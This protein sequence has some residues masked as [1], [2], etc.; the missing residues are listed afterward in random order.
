MSDRD[1]A[2]VNLAWADVLMGALAA[3]GVEHVVMSPGSRSTP[4]VLAAERRPELHLWVRVDERSAAF[5]ALGL[6]KGGGRPVVLVAT[7]GSAPA[8]WHPAVIEADQGG[9]PLVLLSANR[10]ADLHDCGANQTIDQSRLFGS[11]ARAF[12]AL[13]PPDGRPEWL[14]NLMARTLELALHPRPG[15]V[16]LDVPFAEPLVPAFPPP[17]PPVVSIPLVR[18]TPPGIPDLAAIAGRLSGRPGIIVC[19]SEDLGPEFAPLVA[20][21]ATALGVPI[22]ADPLSNLRFGEHDRSHVLARGDLFLRSPEFAVDPPDWVL[23]FGGRPV[24][25]TVQRHAAGAGVATVLMDADGRWPD[26]DRR[27]THVVRLRAEAACKALLATTPRAAPAGWL[28]RYRASERRAAQAIDTAD[29]FWEA[30]IIERLLARL[31]EDAILFAGNSMPV[32]EIDAF[33]G[34]GQRR[35]RFSGNRGASGIDGG[36]STLIGLAA[37]GEKVAGLLG[38][39]SFFHDLNGLQG[40]RDI[41]ATVIVIDNGGGGIFGYLP[42]AGLAGFREH[43]LTPLDLD[44]RHAAGLFGIGFHSAGSLDEFDRALRASLDSG[45]LDLVVAMVDREASA[46]RHQALWSRAAEGWE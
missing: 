18:E 32:R 20:A 45:H 29:G 14:A 28:E 3:L 16:H 41:D 34:T 37:A 21:L 46:A 26:P 12:T 9:V 39:L 13:P 38:D 7:S 35:L 36:V 31:P 43:W 40:A 24:S 33:S 4:L 23:G 22:F 27:A 6:A 10:P 8:H 17:P 15:P 42:Q 19:G 5:F 30:G 25:K 44:W 11:H 2:A 1:P